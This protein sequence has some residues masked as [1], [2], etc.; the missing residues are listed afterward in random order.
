MLLFLNF[1]YMTK[2]GELVHL[3]LLAYIRYYDNI[4]LPSNRPP[5]S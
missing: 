1:S 2:T 3:N 5:T 4:M